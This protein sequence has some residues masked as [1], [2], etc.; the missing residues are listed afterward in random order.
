MR[1]IG[2]LVGMSRQSTMEYYRII[3]EEAARRLGGLHSAKI[4]L[5]SV[6]FS[7]IEEMQRRGD[8][9]AAGAHLAEAESAVKMALNG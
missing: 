1:T 2:L 8:W 4:V 3:N 9:E 5:Y 7:E 6:D